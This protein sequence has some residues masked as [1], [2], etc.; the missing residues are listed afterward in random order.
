MKEVDVT[1]SEVTMLIEIDGQVHLIAME[2]DNY[3]M[4]SELVKRSI[5]SV[6]PTKVS[7]QEFK[8]FVGLT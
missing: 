4:L 1:K 6:V 3:A 5:K 8:K 7:Q 2:K